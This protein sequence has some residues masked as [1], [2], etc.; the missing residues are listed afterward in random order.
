MAFDE[1]KQHTMQFFAASSECDLE[2][3][4]FIFLLSHLSSPHVPIL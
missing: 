4:F 2:M 1:N 3:L